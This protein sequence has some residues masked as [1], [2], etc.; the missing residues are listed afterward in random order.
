MVM[1]GFDDQDNYFRS[2]VSDIELP[3]RAQLTLKPSYLAD[4]ISGDEGSSYGASV[5]D[6]NGDNHLDIYVPNLN[7]QNRLW[8]GDGLGGFNPNDISGD[9]GETY[10]STV[11][12]VDSD[13]DIDIYTLNQGQNKLWINNGIGIFTAS[14]IV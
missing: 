7:D 10:G 1:W 8:F 12:D 13:G 14:D 4:D 11:F 5:A 3:G 2:D 9:L 6:F